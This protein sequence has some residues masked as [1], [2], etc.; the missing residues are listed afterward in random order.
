MTSKEIKNLTRKRIQ[1]ITKISNS[2]VSRDKLITGS[3]KLSYT[4]AFEILEKRN[5]GSF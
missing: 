4:D 2:M 1:K 3:E 5:I